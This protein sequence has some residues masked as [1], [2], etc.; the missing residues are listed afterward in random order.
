MRGG[1]QVG[2]AGGGRAARD[3]AVSL[4]LR[5][6][7]LGLGVVVTLLLIRT[8]GDEGFGEWSTLF[9]VG[10]IAASFGSLGLERVA[11]ERAAAEPARE[12]QW[13]GAL[14]TLCFL[15]SVPVA[16]LSFVVLVAVLERD[17]LRPVAAVVSVTVVA[18]ALSS[19]GVAFELRARNK[20]LTGIELANGVVWAGLVVAIAVA[21]GGILALALAFAALSFTTNGIE[22]A[23]AVRVAGITVRGVRRLWGPLLRLGIP[24]GAGTL[25]I[26]AYGYVDQVLVYQLAGAR[27]AGL[28]GAVY[29]V[30]E[31][32]QFIP[33]TVLVTLFPI[34]VA[35]RD[36]D[37]GRV[38][39]V[40]QSAIDFLLITALAP[41]AITLAG[42][43]PLTV[44]LFGEEFRAAAPAFPV[45]MGAF[46]LISLGYLTG[47]LV[48]AYGLQ[49]RFVFY[50]LAG[51]AF[52]VAG[53]LLLIPRYG[54]LGAA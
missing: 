14:Q 34:L 27:E 32:I 8:L 5:V 3:I 24:V 11:V 52:N 1:E 19:V 45:L 29:K 38:D 9:A 16:L 28:Y 36:V 18:S 43:E 51:L 54:F 31:R 35:A 39:R 25:L 53:N 26:L 4:A 21:G 22:A 33:A 23:L 30:L 2:R 17:A 37:P 41:L 47:Y 6:L 20:V 46:V 10:T 48:I 13:L 42:A 44:L 49:K 7:N 50:A 12:A 15:L 40:V